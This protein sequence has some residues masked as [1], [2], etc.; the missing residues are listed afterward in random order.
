MPK[1]PSAGRIRA[2]FQ[3]LS[4]C[5]LS[6]ALDRLEMT[7]QV[8]GILPLWAGCPKVAGPAMTMKLSPTATYSTVIG[9]LE[10]VQ[11]SAPG[12]LLVIDNGGRPGINSYG[13]IAAFSTRHYGMQGCVIDGSTRDV[14]E[15]ADLALPVY[16]RGVVN[17]SVRGRIG[18]E[19]H[20]SAVKLGDVTVNPGDFVF[21]DVNGV[22]VVPPEAV[23]EVLRWARRFNQMEETIKRDIASGTTPVTAHNRRRYDQAARRPGS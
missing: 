14:D 23:L 2:A 21:A 10:A 5:N 6:D 3:G 19:G 18:F 16:G 8:Q 22:V 11:A 12:D 17:T 15:M 20:G 7:G 9:T 13:G 1:S 4:T